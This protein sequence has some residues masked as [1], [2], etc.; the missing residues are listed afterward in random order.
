LSGGERRVDLGWLALLGAGI[1]IFFWPAVSLKGAFFV[2]DIMV[3]NYPFRHFFAQALAQGQ[4]PL[5]NPAINCGFPLFA[6]GQAGALYPPNMLLALVLPTYA[7]LSLNIAGHLWLG[8]AGMYGLLRALGTG[9]SAGLCAGLCYAL[10]GYMVVR[11]MSPNFVAACAWVPW[12]FLLL[13]LALT[14]RR[15]F[16][17]L[18]LA[19][20][21]SMQL[22]AGHPQA[23]V[24][25]L[26]AAMA[27]G[28][29]RLWIQGAGW[30]FGAAL[31][32][33]P[34]LG[35]GLACVQ[36][37]PTVELV[38]I[39][40][41]GGGLSWDHFAAMS[42]PPERLITLLLP[43]FFGNSAHGT[44]WSRDTGFFIQ[45]C[46][47]VGVLPLLFSWVALRE[48]RDGHT[49][50][51]AL[52]ALAGLVL[53]LGKY[54]ALFSM[55]YQVPGFSS[56][57]IPTRFLLFFTLG[58]SALC[59]LG[60]DRVLRRGVD[61]RLRGVW[62]FVAV[63]GLAALAMLYVN[64]TDLYLGAD[65]AWGR[66]GEPLARYVHHLRIDVARLGGVLILGLWFLGR[67]GQRAVALGAPLVI[68]VELYSFGADF[69]QT[70]EP[71]V[72]TQTPETARAIL[73]DRPEAIA[74]PRIIS[75]V[76]ERNSPFDWHGG[77]V[78]DLDS[79]RRYPE[80]LRMYAGGLYGLANAL[81][82]WSP[83]HLYRHGEF[84]R[85]YPAFAPLAS[86]EYAVQYG[87][88][89]GRNLER[90]HEG[91]I[92]V[93]RMKGALP[94]A[95][96][97]G[98]YY[99]EADPDRR[100]AFMRRGLSPRTQVVLEEEPEGLVGS[101]GEAQIMRYETDALA[102]KLGKHEGGIL[103]LTDTHYPGWKAFV[104]GVEKRVLRAN[105][106]FRA[107]LIPKGAREVVFSYQPSS[108]RYGAWMSLGSLALW[109][110][111][112]LW[113]RRAAFPQIQP[114]PVGAG[115]PLKAW[116]VQGV[117]IVLLHALAT[118]GPLWSEWLV[119]S[120]V[121]LGL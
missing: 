23:A 2:Q 71:D 69:N 51:F 97:V 37:L 121:G 120:R 66:G 80:T 13:D 68:F 21:V 82:G 62:P 90:V 100:L 53:A 57:R 101:G 109:V 94:R 56:F 115:S 43:N 11:A 28:V 10:G 6:E 108:F 46:A 103:V 64:G 26:A 114:M 76:N 112:A 119:R 3:Q 44:Y 99:L 12:L 105:H 15:W 19:L 89:W 87:R 25:G 27:Y 30:R 95:Y 60:V 29:Y 14:R 67:R 106:V 63:L 1:A 81:P 18:L 73:A 107:V 85:G 78:Y 110:V 113:G 31:L 33:A 72:Y 98:R 83:L 52:L 117:L 45:L 96:L 118:Q 41:R 35:A 9:R 7:A 104:D 116:T 8:G 5:W 111:L 42:L 22:F 32:A 16:F 39:S 70:I 92:G 55:L 20:V 48:R 74:P 50:F 93:A 49:G 61:E 58:A 59:G 75:L 84:S 40:N 24:Y 4:L 36:L 17:I 88:G 38:Q 86:V 47:Y 79:Y 102:I 54:T 77:W 65:G 91:D 34:V